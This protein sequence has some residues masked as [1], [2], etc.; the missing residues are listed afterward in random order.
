MQNAPHI[1]PTEL[2][3]DNAICGVYL[4]ICGQIPVVIPTQPLVLL[5]YKTRL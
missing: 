4:Q 5:H 1:N 3:S 2:V